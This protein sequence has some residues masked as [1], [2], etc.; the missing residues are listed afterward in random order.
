MSIEEEISKE[1]KRQWEHLWRTTA[2][3]AVIK[4]VEAHIRHC[5]PHVE[6]NITNKV[7]EQVSQRLDQCRSG[8]ATVPRNAGEP[9][10]AA[11]DNRLDVEINKA[12]ELIAVAHGRT[13]DAIR[14]RLQMHAKE[15][16][17]K[18]LV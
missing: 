15:Q 18:P 13:N 6:K 11:E 4:Q 7:T 10:C 2:S 16:L 17:R 5:S 8:S 9:W 12:I 1:V 3:E 14:A